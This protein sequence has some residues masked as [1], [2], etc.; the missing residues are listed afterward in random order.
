DVIAARLVERRGAF[1]GELAEPPLT[2]DG[3]AS[4]AARLA[5]EHDVSLADSHAYGDSIS[6]LP[7]LELVGNPHAVNPDFRLAREA[8]RRGWAVHEWGPEPGARAAP[9]APVRVEG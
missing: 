1:T 2:A 8:R 6:D 3:R 5:A 9:P 7:M 4:L